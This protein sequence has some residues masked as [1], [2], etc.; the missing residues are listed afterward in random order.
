VLPDYNFPVGLND[1]WNPHCLHVPH[2]TDTDPRETS[3]SIC[4]PW[5]NGAVHYNSAT[6]N[7]AFSLL[8]DGALVEGGQ[9][10][11]NSLGFAK[12]LHIYLRA[13][14][15]CQSSSSTFALHSQ[16][17]KQAC[18]SL[19]KAQRPLKDWTGADLASPITLTDCAEVAEAMLMTQM[20]DAP[21][22]S[23]EDLLAVWYHYGR[24]VP[25]E[26]GYTY[27]VV[28]GLQNPALAQ[29]C[30]IGG[31][32]LNFITYGYVNDEQHLLTGTDDSS[33]WN[34]IIA[35]QVPPREHLFDL[36]TNDQYLVEVAK[37]TTDIDN[38]EWISATDYYG[39]FQMAFTYYTPPH[40]V[41]VYPFRGSVHGGEEVTIRGDHFER[42]TA[43]SA[44]S[45]QLDHDL[46]D[47]LIVMF[48]D[49]VAPVVRVENSTEHNQDKLI[50]MPPE[51]APADVEIKITLDG[52]N[53]GS[54]QLNRTSSI[55]SPHSNLCTRTRAASCLLPSTTS[56]S[57]TNALSHVT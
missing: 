34:N 21:C 7:Y 55:T 2:T 17:L 50:V 5:D 41:E 8:V 25:E 35:C 12:T 30:R 14:L 57:H 6:A 19:T 51:H 10:N 46:D 15:A 20:E 29:N 56:P 3:E 42:F 37:D 39:E 44:E 28:S 26:G 1:L 23:T 54:S 33:A 24:H 47:C 49:V 31:D 13:K 32:D 40:M 36:G 43:C 11:I 16:C 52:G 22:D 45:F 48:G 18:N 38:A 27:A 4:A 9:Y 53:T